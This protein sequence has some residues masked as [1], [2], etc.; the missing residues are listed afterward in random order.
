MKPK[1]GYYAFYQNSE[2]VWRYCQISKIE[3]SFV[4][5]VWRSYEGGLSR[6]CFDDGVEH[7]RMNPLI[8]RKIAKSFKE[9]EMMIA[10][11]LL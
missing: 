11:E 4:F 1:V 9:M 2:N 5:G 10:G 3:G 6:K 8:G 7:M